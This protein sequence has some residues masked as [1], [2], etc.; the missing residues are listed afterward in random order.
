[1]SHKNRQSA[2]LIPN[3]SLVFL[4]PRRCAKGSKNGA[5]GIITM[6]GL[7]DPFLISQSYFQR[8]NFY[9]SLYKCKLSTEENIIT[10]HKN[11]RKER[12]FAYIL[13]S[14]LKTQL[15]QE[16][17]HSYILSSKFSKVY[18]FLLRCYFGFLVF[19][20]NMTLLLEINT[21]YFKT[22]IIINFP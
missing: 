3:L 17:C 15:V 9:C 14:S 12:G 16:S 10:D 13:Q 19:I 4:Q 11:R 2:R 5:E 21:I 8:T 22:K 20:N 1:M 6:K 18:I 7:R